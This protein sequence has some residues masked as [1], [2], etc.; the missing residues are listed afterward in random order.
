MAD[1]L[2]G[3]AVTVCG[4][5][6]SGAPGRLLSLASTSTAPSCMPSLGAR[7]P[8]R[9]HTFSL[10][11]S[12]LFLTSFCPPALDHRAYGQG[13]ETDLSS[14]AKSASKRHGAP[15]ALLASTVS[16]QTISLKTPR[17]SLT[18]ITTEWERN[19][20]WSVRQ[21]ETHERPTPYSPL[22]VVYNLARLIERPSAHRSKRSPSTRR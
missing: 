2:C 12:S 10:G 14:K 17:K 9:V 1:R 13:N 7:R 3:S 6:T 18:S 4:N 5:N 8:R 20:S 16:P 15:S 21:P 19:T 11:T 22:A